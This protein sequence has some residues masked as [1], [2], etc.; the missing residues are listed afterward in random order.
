MES[1]PHGS[2][3]SRIQ[4]LK[5]AGDRR[6]SSGDRRAEQRYAL[7]D[8]VTEVVVLRCCSGDLLQADLLDI[9]HSAA[10]LAIYPEVQLDLGDR[11]VIRWRAVSGEEVSLDGTAVRV[12]AHEMITVIVISFQA[13][14]SRLLP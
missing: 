4:G 1:A 12:E 7:G 2:G 5:K 10:R 8:E 14:S 13:D 11:C 3:L 9:S 6:Q